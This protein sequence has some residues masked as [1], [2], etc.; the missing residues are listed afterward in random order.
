MTKNI[1]YALMLGTALFD[2]QEPQRK[3]IEYT[4]KDKNFIFYIPAECKEIK[5]LNKDFYSGWQLTCKD[6]S[7]KEFFY[8]KGA[9]DEQW[10][11]YEIVRK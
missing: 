5:S 7:G 10:D 8:S 4:G 3:D 6:Q 11:R 1:I 9:Y 2:C